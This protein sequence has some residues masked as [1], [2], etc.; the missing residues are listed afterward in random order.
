M[1]ETGLAS[2]GLHMQDSVAYAIRA[3]GFTSFAVNAEE[4]S[5]LSRTDTPAWTTTQRIAPCSDGR[6]LLM[7]AYPGYNHRGAAMGNGRDSARVSY[8]EC[9]NT[10]D[11]RWCP[12]DSMFASHYLHRTVMGLIGQRWIE[13]FNRKAIFNLADSSGATPARWYSPLTPKQYWGYHGEPELTGRISDKANQAT[14]T[15]VI[16]VSASSLGSGPWGTASPNMPGFY[17]I[18]YAVNVVRAINQLDGRTLISFTYPDNL[19]PKDIQR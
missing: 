8:A 9:G 18:K 2:I 11:S 10:L 16:R 14:G 19:S 12:N 15:N 6:F 3:A 17:Q 5:T 7:L 13:P 1:A 4:D